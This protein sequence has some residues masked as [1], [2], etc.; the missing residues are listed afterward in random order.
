MLCVPLTW[1]PSLAV[2]TFLI[3]YAIIAQ[4]KLAGEITSRSPT[5]RYLAL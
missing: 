1:V 2:K 4:F 5:G 3:S